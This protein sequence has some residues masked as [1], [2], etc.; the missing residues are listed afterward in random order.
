LLPSVAAGAA[1]ELDDLRRACRTAIDRVFGAEPDA[2]VVVGGGA[3]TTRYTA[4]DFGTFDGFGVRET[5]PLGGV[6]ALAVGARMPL[7]LAVGA[8]LLHDRGT[9]P[10]RRGQSVA[11]DTPVDGCR[12]LGAAL[13][14]EPERIGLI[15]MGDGSACR[16][17]KSPGY[18]DPRAEPFDTSVATALSAGDA[19]A[20]LALDAGLAAELLAA[21]RAPWQVLAGAALTNDAGWQGDVLYDEAPYGVTYLAA[22]W[23]TRR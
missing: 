14:A 17:E 20:L 3:T 23:L 15:V 9:G 16:G 19:E 21:G 8:W 5:Y 4:G 1:A 18:A 10:G 22:T 11:A 13:A 6:D 2:L 12:S 7:S